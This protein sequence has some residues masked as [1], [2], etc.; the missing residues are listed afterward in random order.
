M[1]PCGFGWGGIIRP[2]CLLCRMCCARTG[3]ELVHV[4]PGP[5]S[6]IYS[7]T[8]GPCLNCLL[9]RKDFEV[10]VR[11][12]SSVSSILVLPW[13]A[14]A[15][16]RSSHHPRAARSSWLG[17]CHGLAGCSEA[18]ADL[19]ASCAG[20]RGRP[21]AGWGRALCPCSWPRSQG[22]GL[23]QQ[24]KQPGRGPQNPNKP[25]PHHKQA[26][27]GPKYPKRPWPTRS[28]FFLLSPS[29]Y[30]SCVPV[31]HGSGAHT[32]CH[33]ASQHSRWGMDGWPLPVE[34]KLSPSR[35]ALL[36]CRSQGL[37]VSLGN[38]LSVL[39]FWCQVHT[40]S[41]E[42]WRML[43]WPV[44][45]GTHVAPSIILPGVS[46]NWSQCA[47]HC[48]PTAMGAA[49]TSSLRFPVDFHCFELL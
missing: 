22:W 40:V 28:P 26:G 15:V 42:K 7:R 36:C 29:G 6:P 31:C 33:L 16:C 43:V 47:L 41:L 5:L 23:P 30:F 25:L 1:L 10:V 20:G 11:W 27:A 8:W 21:P 17:L 46:P 18:A 48:S 19:V 2:T 12:C 49:T 14:V 37:S 39:V 44:A 3:R 24:G 34:S 35:R 38:L 45:T 13:P 32:L 4:M 9:L